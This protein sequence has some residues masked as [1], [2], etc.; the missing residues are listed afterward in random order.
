[1][2]NFTI[3]LLKTKKFL[4]FFFVFNFPLK[5]L[6]YNFIKYDKNILY[7][8]NI[9]NYFNFTRLPKNFINSIRLPNYY[10]AGFLK[11]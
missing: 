8:N 7:K 2:R 9:S 11:T 6:K 4:I 5:F 3:K 1:M 10:S